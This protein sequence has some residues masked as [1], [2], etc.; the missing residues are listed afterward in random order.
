MSRSL[1]PINWRITARPCQFIEL[2]NPLFQLASKVAFGD[3]LGGFFVE[4]G[5]AAADA[6]DLDIAGR[7]ND[8]LGAVC[9]MTPWIRAHAQLLVARVAY[10]NRRFEVSPRASEAAESGFI[11][12]GRI[13]FAVP[14]GTQSNHWRRLARQS[15]RFALC[16]SPRSTLRKPANTMTVLSKHILLLRP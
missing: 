15:A 11:T 10:A 8:E 14:A 1:A 7:C 6:R 13:R 3:L 4:L 12:M 9:S 16:G 2:S 5:R